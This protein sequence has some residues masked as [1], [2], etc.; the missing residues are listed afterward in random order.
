[1]TAAQ[2]P[3]CNAL[4]V[5]AMETHRCAYATT[6][7]LPLLLLLLDD[8]RLLLTHDML[9]GHPPFEVAV[10]I[11]RRMKSQARFDLCKRTLR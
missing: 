10:V 7:L 5:S 4:S 8:S 2:P 6:L 3:Y 11:D 9:A 1:M